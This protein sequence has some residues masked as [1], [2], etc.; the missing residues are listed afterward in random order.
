MIDF[1]KPSPQIL[2]NP[3]IVIP[4]DNQVNKLSLSTG[5]SWIFF[6]IFII[7]FLLHGPIIILSILISPYLALLFLFLFY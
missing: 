2:D 7:I 6:L 3:Y 4:E 1:E 5:K